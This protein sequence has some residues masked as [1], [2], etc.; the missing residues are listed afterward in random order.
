M[1]IVIL[2][3]NNRGFKNACT[4][5]RARAHKHAFKTK[6]KGS[7]IGN[8]QTYLTTLGARDY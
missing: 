4:H 1:P 2:I 6:R 8:L 5:T 3:I 7:F